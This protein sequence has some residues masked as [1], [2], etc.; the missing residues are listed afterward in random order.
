MLIV[1]YFVSEYIKPIYIVERGPI[2]T[3]LPFVMVFGTLINKFLKQILVFFLAAFFVVCVFINFFKAGGREYPDYRDAAKIIMLNAGSSGTIIYPGVEKYNIDYYLRK[4]GS[5]K[6]VKQYTFPAEK[7]KMVNWAKTYKEISPEMENELLA[8]LMQ[9]RSGF[10]KNKS[11]LCTYGP[12]EGMF[13]D[14]LDKAIKKYFVLRKKV[15]IGNRVLRV[16]SL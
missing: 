6:K 15:S 3:Y 1:P 5:D 14:D 7:Q 9:I 8:Q 11:I 12:D 10:I 13:P 16:Y 4:D 2:I